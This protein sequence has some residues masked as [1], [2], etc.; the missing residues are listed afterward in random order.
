MSTSGLGTSVTPP[1][2]RLLVSTHGSSSAPGRRGPIA[3]APSTTIT[4]ATPTAGNVATS[5]LRVGPSVVRGVRAKRARSIATATRPV[6]TSSRDSRTR[7]R[8]VP[9]AATNTNRTAPGTSASPR[10]WAWNANVSPSS[11]TKRDADEPEHRP[12]AFVGHGRD[13]LG[14]L[15][16]DEREVGREGVP[17]RPRREERGERLRVGEPG[18]E[19]GQHD[20][21]HDDGDD[22]GNPHDPHDVGEE[23]A[24]DDEHEGVGEEVPRRVH[25][26]QADGGGGRERGQGHRRRRVQQRL[27]LDHVGHGCTDAS[28]ALLGLDGPF[29]R[30][31]S[32]PPW[33][34]SSRR[35]LIRRRSRPGPRCRRRARSRPRHRSVAGG[36]RRGGPSPRGTA[37]RSGRRPRAAPAAR[38]SAR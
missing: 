16:P 28:W 5:G 2:P 15:R 33:R 38:A 27:A 24:G 17:G 29:R 25:A 6:A 26:D 10:P 35:S 22:A 34:W 21:Q 30:R 7:P 20:R 36:P 23:V 18:R 13:R 4:A 11:T 1:P 19:D 31:E 14:E 12:A 32:T 37:R 3:Q 9:R 8:S